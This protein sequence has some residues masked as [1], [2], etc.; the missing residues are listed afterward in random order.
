MSLPYGESVPVAAEM[1]GP[2][3]QHRV[4]TRAVLNLQKEISEYRAGKDGLCALLWGVH[5]C[6][7]EVQAGVGVAWVQGLWTLHG[8]GFWWEALGYGVVFWVFM[9]HGFL[10]L[11]RLEAYLA[12]GGPALL[13]KWICWFA[14]I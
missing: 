7:S 5:L 13:W 3:V 12:A 14:W 1:Y 2:D 11:L 6:R 9:L 8:I 4:C 10:G